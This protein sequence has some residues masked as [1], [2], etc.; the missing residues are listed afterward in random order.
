MQAHW[1][2]ITDTYIDC[3]YCSSC[4]K[5]LYLSKV[6]MYRLIDDEGNVHDIRCKECF[7][8]KKKIRP[9]KIKREPPIGVEESSD[10]SL[11]TTLWGVFW[12][13]F[14]FDDK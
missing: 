11:I 12:F 7:D 1:V 9:R 3:F 8:R 6:K 10:S 14:L 2:Y 13:W 4:E 5:F